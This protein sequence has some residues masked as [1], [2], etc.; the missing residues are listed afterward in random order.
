MADALDSETARPLTTLGGVEPIVHMLCGTDSGCR[1]LLESNTCSRR[2]PL[3]GDAPTRDAA[4]RTLQKGCAAAITNSRDPTDHCN[5]CLHDVEA[6]PRAASKAAGTLPSTE[7]SVR[8]TPTSGRRASP[9]VPCDRSTAC[10]VPVDSMAA[11]NPVRPEASAQAT[12][13]N[14][15]AAARWL[16]SSSPRL[17]ATSLAARNAISHS[18]TVKATG[19]NFGKGGRLHPFARRRAGMS[20]EAMSMSWNPCI[21]M[22]R[23]MAMLLSTQKSWPQDSADLWS[24]S[25]KSIIRTVSAATTGQRI[26]NYGPE[27]CNHLGVASAT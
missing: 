16:R 21:P 2:S 8:P 3:R 13:P 9:Y 12:P 20:I 24:P 23:K 4:D 10:R 22:R 18:G 1:Y 26:S 11:P 25:R 17:D 15:T 27:V 19:G 5:H 7:D 14:I 6:T